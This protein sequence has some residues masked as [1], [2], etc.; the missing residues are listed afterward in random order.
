[1]VLKS[2]AEYDGS[3]A[4]QDRLLTRILVIVLL[5]SRFLG[6]NGFKSLLYAC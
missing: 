3:R 1:M 6:V 5:A 2:N 4:T